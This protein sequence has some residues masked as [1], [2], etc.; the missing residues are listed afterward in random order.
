[1][2]GKNEEISAANAQ[3]ARRA[4]KHLVASVWKQL[5]QLAFPPETEQHTI[6]SLYEEKLQIESLVNENR[7]IVF[8]RDQLVKP[9]RKISLLDVLQELVDENELQ[10]AV[11]AAICLMNK[12]A[13]L[14]P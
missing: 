1:M 11:I 9:V 4:G 6:E 8:S 10:S 14:I 3:V 5:F 7:V 2:E 12:S 13:S